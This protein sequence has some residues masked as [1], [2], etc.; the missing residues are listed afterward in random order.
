MGIGRGAFALG[1]GLAS[2]LVGRTASAE[3][4]AAA[5]VQTEDLGH[6]SRDVGRL[7][8]ARAHFRRCSADACP[9]EI[10]DA[11]AEALRETEERIPSIVV[12]ARD[13]EHRVV[14][15]AHVIVDGL[16]LAAV[17]D[18]CELMVDP[19]DRLVRIE[20]AGFLP[21]TMRVDVPQGSHGIPVHVAL[22]RPRHDVP[23]I[24]PPLPVL[25]EVEREHVRPSR[26]MWALP[27]A[28]A[29]LTLMAGGFYAAMRSTSDSLVF[30]E[31]SRHALQLTAATTIPVG[32]V[33]FIFGLYKATTPSRREPTTASIL[34]GTF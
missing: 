3:A 13:D 6:R 16:E 15:D 20:R 28:L 29:G 1:V 26:P 31:T 10:R 12:D 27:M 22:M 23:A 4:T 11:C 14:K 32:A 33:A 18:D 17:T 7:L 21:V 8:D 2:L 19:G 5:C 34:N 9:T 30:D 25:T 24:P